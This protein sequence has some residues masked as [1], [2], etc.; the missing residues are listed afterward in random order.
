MQ[1]STLHLQ[2]C[3]C[4]SAKHI[5]YNLEAACLTTAQVLGGIS[6]WEGGELS[7]SAIA[8][9]AELACRP[10]VKTSSPVSCFMLQICHP[11]LRL[12]IGSG[13]FCATDVVMLLISKPVS[14]LL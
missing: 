13:S 11:S 14:F 9:C 5:T 2:L 12:I 3:A 4:K 8:L 7:S 6:G 10:T 1:S